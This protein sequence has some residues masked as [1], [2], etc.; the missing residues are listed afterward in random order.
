VSTYEKFTTNKSLSA[1]FD[2]ACAQVELHIIQEC[3]SL[4]LLALAVL[5]LREKVPHEQVL[6]YD[7]GH[8]DPLLGLARKPVDLDLLDVCVIALLLHK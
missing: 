7:F 6:A 3:L 8:P 4:S 2:N 1:F 5:H